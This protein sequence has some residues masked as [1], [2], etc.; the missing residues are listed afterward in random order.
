MDTLIVAEELLPTERVR[1]LGEKTIGQPGCVDD[2]ENVLEAQPAGSLSVTDTIKV[3][4][5][6]AF[7]LA[8]DDVIV[9]AG[10]ATTHAGSTVRFAVAVAVDDPAVAVVFTA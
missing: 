7:A 2:R 1:L 9:T 6:P 10:L 8:L 3:T 4:L 5:P